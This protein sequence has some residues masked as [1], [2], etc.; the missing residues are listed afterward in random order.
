M[1]MNKKK[2]MFPVNRPPEKINELEPV[3]R[4]VEAP[5]NRYVIPFQPSLET[6]P[7]KSLCLNTLSFEA[8]FYSFLSL[9][10]KC[11]FLDTSSKAATLKEA[12]DMLLHL[13][14]RFLQILLTFHFPCGNIK[15]ECW[16]VSFLE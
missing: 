7:C 4:F 5:K 9:G 12:F 2:L 8:F 14:T 6:S 15:C 10:L 1:L 11:N 13:K 3:A 16:Y